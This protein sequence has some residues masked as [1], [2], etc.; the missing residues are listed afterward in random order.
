MLEFRDVGLTLDFNLAIS[1][2][3]FAI[4][5][6]CFSVACWSS[7]T[8]SISSA[9]CFDR[10][11][12]DGHSG[13]GCMGS[14]TWRTVGRGA[15]DLAHYRRSASGGWPGEGGSENFPKPS[16]SGR[17]N[18]VSRSTDAGLIKNSGSTSSPVNAYD[19]GGITSATLDCGC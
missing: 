6:V 4:T 12:H 3:C 14:D 9:I 5:P 7:F 8:S 18:R 17:L 11:A 15:A 16:A 1:L 2:A 13:S 19:M 10:S